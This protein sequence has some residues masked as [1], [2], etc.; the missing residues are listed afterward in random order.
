MSERVYLKFCDKLHD[1]VGFHAAQCPVCSARL[2]ARGTPTSFLAGVLMMII[3]PLVCLI[4]LFG[5]PLYYSFDGVP[6][7]V[8][9]GRP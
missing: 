3:V 6:H 4:I 7:E 8:R 5:F 1:E 9:I 2:E